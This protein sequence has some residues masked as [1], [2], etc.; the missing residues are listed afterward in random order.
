MSIDLKE[1]RFNDLYNL[2]QQGI[3][4]AIHD[5]ENLSFIEERFHKENL[6]YHWFVMNYG[7]DLVDEAFLLIK[8]WRFTPELLF[9]M[10]IYLNITCNNG[11]WYMQSADNVLKISLDHY[12]IVYERNDEIY[13]HDS[14]DKEFNYN[15][16]FNYFVYAD[17]QVL[18]LDKMFKIKTCR[19]LAFY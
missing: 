15:N 10:R 17:Y 18:E 4:D 1:F 2:Y 11:I 5:P 3:Y 7:Q 8:D 12:H 9:T 6:W 13:R 19:Y 14:S 16:I